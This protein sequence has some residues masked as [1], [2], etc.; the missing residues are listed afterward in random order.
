MDAAAR[1]EFEEHLALNASRISSEKNGL[2]ALPSQI[3]DSKLF[4]SVV[5]K[6]YGKVHQLDNNLTGKKAFQTRKANAREAR[7][8]KKAE[9]KQDQLE[10]KSGGAIRKAK[11]KNRSKGVY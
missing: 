3:G 10:A 11:H 8:A 7:R 6:Q 2:A 1:R 9:D 4:H 5:L